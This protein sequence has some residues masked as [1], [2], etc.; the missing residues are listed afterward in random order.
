MQ[1]MR[2][3]WW[4][5]VRRPFCGSEEPVGNFMPDNEAFPKLIPHQNNQITGDELGLGKRVQGMTN[6]DFLIKL[7]MGLSLKSK[8]DAF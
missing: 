2:F 5:E 1:E 3:S 4:A 7:H 8:A 6:L